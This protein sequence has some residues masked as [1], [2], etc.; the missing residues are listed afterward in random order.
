MF[1]ATLRCGTVLNY[2]VR[3]FVPPLGEPV[4]CR[5]HGYCV[6]DACG[7][8]VSAN[9]VRRAAARARPR[10]QEE[11]LEWMSDRRATT[12]HALRQHR[13]TLRMVAAAERDGLVAVDL[14]AGTVVVR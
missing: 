14:E 13:F 11:L 10:V 2:E 8:T 1:T 3:S 4:P 6:V 12:L 7:R 5:R 9:L